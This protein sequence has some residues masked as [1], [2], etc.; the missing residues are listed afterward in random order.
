MVQV[1]DGELGAGLK[2]LSRL[3]A[4]GHDVGG[5][6]ETGHRNVHSGGLPTI[7]AV[8]HRDVGGGDPRGRVAV[9]VGV[10]RVQGLVAQAD[11]EG[12]GADELGDI[13]VFVAQVGD[14]EGFSDG[15]ITRLCVESR[16]ETASLSRVG[17]QDFVGGEH[18]FGRSQHGYAGNQDV[19][20]VSIYVGRRDYR[21]I[22]KP[23][24]GGWVVVAVGVIRVL[25]HVF[26][27]G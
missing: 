23:D 20:P 3:D 27:C 9:A 13:Q 5:R 18:A 7:W 8:D 4:E 1:L 15:Q 10:V 21:H 19:E 24:A 2:G 17:G 22:G 25:K 12:P 16:R 11:V 6:V 14:D 26:Q